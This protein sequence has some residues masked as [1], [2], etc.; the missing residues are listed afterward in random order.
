MSRFFVSASIDR[1]RRAGRPWFVKPTPV[2]PDE[3]TYAQWAQLEADPR[4]T[5][6]DTQAG[7]TP[8]DVESLQARIAELEAENAELKAQLEPPNTQCHDEK[9]GGVNATDAATTG[10]PES[11][12][13]AA[14]PESAGAAAVS[15]QETIAI[16]VS[17]IVADDNDADFTKSG[18][19]RPLL[20]AVRAASGLSDVTGAERDAA[21][22]EVQRANLT[23]A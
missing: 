15:R 7:E 5:V 23:G 14:A 9:G 3:F 8:N 22:A 20:S 13:G 19:R 12:H 11:P 10:S 6:F 2:E 21:L 1:Y 18:E 17:Q 16:A 4:I